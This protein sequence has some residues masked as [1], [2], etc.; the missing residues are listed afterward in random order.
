MKQPSRNF[1]KTHSLISHTTCLAVRKTFLRLRYQV[2]T[3]VMFEYFR[4]SQ[5]C[6][7]NISDSHSSV[8]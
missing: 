1:L 5:Q 8:G 7:L 6:C 3:A 4:F 2:L